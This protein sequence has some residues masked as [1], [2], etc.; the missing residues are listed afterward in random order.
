MK[1]IVILILLTLFSLTSNADGVR[2]L[3]LSDQE[4]INAISMYLNPNS[5]DKDIATSILIFEK[6]S[7]QDLNMLYYYGLANYESKT[8]LL[9][10]N[11]EEGAKLIEQAAV[12]GD[13]DANYTYAMMLLKANKIKEG[14]GYLEISAKK[15]LPKA[16]YRLG[17]MYYQGNGVPRNRQ[18]GFLLINNAAEGEEPEAQY[19]LAKIY[20]SQEDLE[21]QRKGIYWLKKAVINKNYVACSDLYKIYFNGILVEKDIQQHLKYLKCSANYKDKD[22]MYTL[23]NYYETGKYM[24][25]DIHGAGYWYKELAE[26]VKDP[27]ASLKYAQ[28]LLS[29]FPNDKIKTTDAVKYLNV[30]SQESMEASYLLGSIYKNGWYGVKVN[31]TNALRNFERAK[32]LGSNEAQKEIINL[33]NKK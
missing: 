2:K 32:K 30:A 29:N 25:K 28:Y 20:F 6:Y 8:K 13:P 9:T 12:K 23:A 31:T 26:S 7:A 22:A 16:E 17:K 10:L 21:I 19:D 27:E 15:G 1:K 4:K 11:K 3:N 14:I 33:L 18:S 5:E 24:S